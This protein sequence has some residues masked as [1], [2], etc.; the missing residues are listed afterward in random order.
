MTRE[1]NHLLTAARKSLPSPRTPGVCM[2]RTELAILVNAHI[3]H[4]E[5]NARPLDSRSIGS[6]ERGLYRWPRDFV[7]MAFRAALNAE[8]D[9]ALGFYPGWRNGLPDDQF[10]VSTVAPTSDVALTPDIVPTAAVVPTADVRFDMI[11]LSSGSVLV[12]DRR[13]TAYIGTSNLH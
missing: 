10:P 13:R 9:M 8:S 1:P 2:S 3:H 5:P 7:R 11:S 12:T 4:N 6:Y